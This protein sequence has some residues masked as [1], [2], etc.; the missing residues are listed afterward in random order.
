MSILPEELSTFQYYVDKLPM[1]LKD[2]ESFIEHFK[3]WFDVLMGNTEDDITGLVPSS[4]KLLSLIDVFNDDY[5]NIINSLEGTGSDILDKLGSIFN[6]RRSFSVTHDVEGTLTNFPISLDNQDFLT[7]IRAQIIKNYSNGTYQQM[8][9]FYD[10]SKLY[11]YFQSTHS[12][13]VYCY[14]LNITGLTDYTPSENIQHLFL[15]GLLTI[16]S[17]GIQYNYSIQDYFKMLIWDKE[18]DESYTGWNYGEW[19]I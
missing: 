14:L 9:E 12:A 4:D 15:A 17:M 13:E 8:R 10:K 11:V 2:S 1:Y 18:I 7:L 5:L 19:V 6:V 3:I 16:E